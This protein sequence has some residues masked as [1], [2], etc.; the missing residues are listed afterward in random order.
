MAKTTCPERKGADKGR[1]TH[2]IAWRERRIAELE[3]QIAG[4]REKSMLLEALLICALLKASQGDG[5][6][7]RIRLGRAE[8]SEQLGKWTSAC[9]VDGEDYEVV[10][11]PSREAA[12]AAPQPEC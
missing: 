8:V 6:E 2:A 11:H 4:E 1:V 5:K 3:E 12:D 9:R 7:R 10:F